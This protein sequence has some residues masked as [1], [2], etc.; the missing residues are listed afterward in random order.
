LAALI[1]AIPA[2]AL[3]VWDLADRIGKRRRAERL[4]VD[5]QRLHVEKSVEIDLI[6]IDGPQALER[7]A[8]DQ[9]LDLAT[10]MEKGTER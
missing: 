9:L 2:A 6:T 1:L 7:M 8:P 4:I 5:A 10:E 3:A